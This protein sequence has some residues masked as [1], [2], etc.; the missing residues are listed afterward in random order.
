[1]VR[2]TP[3]GVHCTG[4]NVSTTPLAPQA[5]ARGSKHNA[6]CSASSNK[7]DG[8][9]RVPWTSAAAPYRDLRENYELKVGC[10]PSA[11]A[12]LARPVRDDGARLCSRIQIVNLRLCHGLNFNGW[13]ATQRKQPAFE[14]NTSRTQ[15]ER[16]R[17]TDRPTDQ[18]IRKEPRRPRL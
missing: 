7:A 11:L 8:F 14:R 5:S 12:T 9:Y 2:P 4:Q 6:S 10:G 3:P 1:M 13:A 18:L 16:K 17:P 15:R